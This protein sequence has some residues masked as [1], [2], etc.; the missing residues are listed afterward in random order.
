MLDHVFVPSTYASKKT[1]P[2]PP[3]TTSTTTSN[4][5]GSP[6]TLLAP[7]TPNFRHTFTYPTANSSCPSAPPPPHHPIFPTA[8]K[9][10]RR[11][12]RSR[13]RPPRHGPD[14]ISIL[15]SRD[16]GAGGEVP[17]FDGFVGRAGV[18]MQPAYEA[19]EGKWAQGDAAVS[20][21]R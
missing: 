20:I 8:N 17:Y 11:A 5:P 16:G 6:A 1:I 4:H 12:I 13:L 10:P 19:I 18:R 21:R 15:D 3:T 2:R 14:L 7:D 9:S